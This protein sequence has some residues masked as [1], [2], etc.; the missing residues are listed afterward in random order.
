MSDFDPGEG[1]RSIGKN[2]IPE[3][4]ESIVHATGPTE[5]TAWV[6]EDPKPPLPTARYTVILVNWKDESDTSP[7][8]IRLG[9]PTRPQWLTDAG[10]IVGNADWVERHITGFEILSEPRAV[11]AKA[12]LEEV[13]EYLPLGFDDPSQ[14]QLDLLADEFGVDA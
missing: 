8:L 13:R 11:T 4:A 3:G 12:L 14:H 10:E 6:R 7:V 5:W 1:W 9:S 2:L